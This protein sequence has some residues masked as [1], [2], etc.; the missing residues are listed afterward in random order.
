MLS[1]FDK[2]FIPA[3]RGKGLMSGFF[4]RAFLP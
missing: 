4:L 1:R 2:A 3:L